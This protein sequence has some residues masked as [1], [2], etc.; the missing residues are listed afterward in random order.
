MSPTA[1]GG[2]DELAGKADLGVLAYGGYFVVSGQT[3]CA[4]LIEDQ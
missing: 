3:N 1:D 4:S 2:H